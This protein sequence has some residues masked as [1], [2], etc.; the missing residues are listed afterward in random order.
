MKSGSGSITNSGPPADAEV[1][2]TIALDEDTL[3][4]W[5]EQKIDPV[6]A[7]MAG[8]L[9]VGGDQMMVLKL[10]VVQD[11]FKDAAA[12]VLQ[13]GGLGDDAASATAPDVAATTPTPTPT[14]ETEAEAEAESTMATDTARGATSAASVSAPATPDAPTYECE[15]DCGF[16][17]GME[18]VTE[19]EHNCHNNPTVAA[20]AIAQKK[21][22][23][24]AA[25]KA[26][27]WGS[28]LSSSQPPLATNSN[29]LCLEY[30][31]GS[32]TGW[33]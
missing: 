17:G 32:H 27:A 28:S 25:D 8:R 22:E 1:S 12:A 7:F 30:A 14:P 5:L 2:T 16:E 23:K 13:G 18:I 11:V 15:Y 19:H 20:A 24:L 6:S 9:V 3:V 10:A 29:A 21:A 33:A 4:E 31:I 26:A